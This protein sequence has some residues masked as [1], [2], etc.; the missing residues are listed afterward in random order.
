MAGFVLAALLAVGAGVPARAASSGTVSGFDHR[1]ARWDA[2]LKGFVK[3]GR[4]DYASLK[5]LGDLEP[6]LAEL[7]A[8]KEKEEESWTK[9]QRLAFWLNARNAFVI[10]A[11]LRAYPIPPRSSCDYPPDSSGFDRWGCPSNSVARIPEMW[12]DKA[13]VAAGRLLSIAELEDDILRRFGEPRVDFALAKG[14]LG[15]P[16]LRGES[17]I[18]DKLFGQLDDDVLRFAGDP[19]CE[20]IDT[21]NWRMGVSPA[22]R[23]CRDDFASFDD[24][25]WDGY[26]KQARGVVAY[27]AQLLPPGTY[28]AIKARPLEFDWLPYD[29]SLNDRPLLER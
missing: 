4:V 18:P 12:T 15:C 9:P 25:S 29:W 27:L 1:Y 21:E 2:L 7:S 6:V 14:A 8:V 11:V 28:S 5:H 10:Q 13:Y 3:D 19:A 23:W 22:L 26:P 20:K 17:Y 24:G 16:S